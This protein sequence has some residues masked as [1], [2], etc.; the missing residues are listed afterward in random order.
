[1]SSIDASVLHG[2]GEG[3]GA[4]APAIHRDHP[5][6]LGIRMPLTAAWITVRLLLVPLLYLPYRLGRSMRWAHE[7]D[8]AV[9]RRCFPLTE[10]ADEHATQQVVPRLREGDPIPDVTVALAGRSVSLPELAEEGRLLVVLYRG[11]WCPYSRLHLGHLAAE[12]ARLQAAGITVVGIT[13]HSR[14][15]WWRAK[16]VSFDMVDDPSGT[17]FDAFGVKA[18]TSLPNRVWGK[19]VPHESVFL[20]ERGGALIAGDVRKL[21]SYRLRQSFLSVDAL[22][23]LAAPREA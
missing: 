9:K 8:A 14:A 1:M 7:L 20:F 18:L 4:R 21:S 12:H 10:R 23:R 6:M 15:W 2:E 17:V 13:A 3:T 19:L 22:L 5:L 16:G 11:N